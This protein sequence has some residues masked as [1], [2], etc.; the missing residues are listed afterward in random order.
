MRCTKARGPV[1]SEDKALHNRPTSSA[2]ILRPVGVLPAAAAGGCDAT[3]PRTLATFAVRHVPS[4]LIAPAVY[5]AGTVTPGLETT[6]HP[7][8]QVHRYLPHMRPLASSARCPFI[9]HTLQIIL[10]TLWYVTSLN[11]QSAVLRCPPGTPWETRMHRLP[12]CPNKARR[13]VGIAE[14]KNA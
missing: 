8:Y 1:I 9:V 4:S 5:R 14:P 12:Q 13:A 11:T 6:A 2:E 10:L 7:D 3:T